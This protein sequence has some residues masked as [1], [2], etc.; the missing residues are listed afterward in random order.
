MRK[1]IK[2]L[3]DGERDPIKL[4]GLVHGRTTNNHGK[5]IITSSL[6]VIELAVIELVEMSKYGCN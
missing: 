1:I 3:I 5:D 2:S 4:C 6:M